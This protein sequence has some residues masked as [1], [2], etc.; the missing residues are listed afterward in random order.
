MRSG[1]IDTNAAINLNE[2]LNSLQGIKIQVEH[3][4][5]PICS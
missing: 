3:Q 5:M 2:F 4:E 1:V